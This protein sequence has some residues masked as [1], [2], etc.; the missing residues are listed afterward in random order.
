MNDPAPRGAWATARAIAASTPATRNRYVDFLRA[1]SICVVVLGHWLVSMPTSNDGGLQA[2]EVMRVIPWAQWLSWAFQVMPVFF[3]VGGYS[4][5]VSWR[6]AQRKGL[7]YG[8]WGATRLQRLAGPLVPLLIF[9]IAFAVVARQLHAQPEW[10]HLASQA[11]LI[12]VW[13]LAVYIVVT[14]AT[15][16]THRLYCAMGSSSFW[17]FALGTATVDLIAFGAG[18]EALRWVNYGFV[19]LAVHQLG[20]M[21]Q[22]GRLAGPRRALP[23][24]IGGLVLLIALVAAAGYP[25]SMLTVPGEAVSNSRPPT[26]ALLALGVFHVG[27]LL[28]L[29]GPAQRWLQRLRPWALTVLVNAHIMTLYLWHLTV[30]LLVAAVA[31]FLAGGASFGTEPGS[32]AWWL[33]RPLWIAVMLAVMLV[34]VVLLG[35]YERAPGGEP[36]PALAAWRVVAGSVLLSTGLGL[37]AA[38]GIGGSGPTGLRLVSVL[39]A[40][41]GLVLVLPRGRVRRNHP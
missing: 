30:M 28:S 26:L 34:F 9:W 32:A 6:S 25:V 37:A 2:P 18:F 39:P 15:P 23:W 16:L 13:F 20:F 24:G 19:W 17:L 27:L 22:N 35:R 33:S 14:A 41:V 29:E 11:A 40:V 8:V 3:V 4:N 38:G 10:V 1:F 7:G 5:A 21:W 31:A 36:R 12:P